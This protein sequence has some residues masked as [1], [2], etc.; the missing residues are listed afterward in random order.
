MCT[1][2]AEGTVYGGYEMGE[3]YRTERRIFQV[4]LTAKIWCEE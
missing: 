1:E 2:K 3:N 4:I